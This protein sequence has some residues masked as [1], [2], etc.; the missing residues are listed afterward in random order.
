MEAVRQV[1]AITNTK[2]RLLHDRSA[3][4]NKQSY[5]YIQKDVADLSTS[6]TTLSRE[7]LNISNSHVIEDDKKLSFELHFKE[8]LEKKLQAKAEV[9]KKDEKAEAE[10]DLEL[11]KEIKIDGVAQTK[12]MHIFLSYKLSDFEQALEKSSHGKNITL[13]VDDLI[14]DIEKL[15]GKEL[16]FSGDSL[17]MN[18]LKNA[19]SGEQ[20][21]IAK[22]LIQLI[23]MSISLANMRKELE[24]KESAYN[25]PQVEKNEQ[26]SKTIP[27]LEDFNIEVKSEETEPLTIE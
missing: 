15:L 2:D 27:K 14:N 11:N 8:R 6:A 25:E 10:F 16:N 4:K 20:E 19:S 26:K 18:D 24:E 7:G 17:N 5:T 21:K 3:S 22:K 12:I 9:D 1:D 13:Y 23:K